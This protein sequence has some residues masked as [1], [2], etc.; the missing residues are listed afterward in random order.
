VV[1]SPLLYFALTQTFDFNA[2]HPKLLS[3]FKHSCLL[4]SSPF[5]ISGRLL[6]LCNGSPIGGVLCSR[7]WQLVLESATSF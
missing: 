6:H 7:S 3:L 4:I 1:G 5:S 2:D